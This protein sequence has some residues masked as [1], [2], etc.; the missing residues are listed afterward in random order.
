[1]YNRS[2]KVD[3]RQTDILS[4]LTIRDVKG[5]SLYATIAVSYLI[6]ALVIILVYIY[7]RKMVQLRKD[8]FR[9]PEYQNSFYARTL[10]ITH[11]P[12][13]LQSDKGINSILDT[14]KMPYPATAVHISRQVGVLPE[15][16]KYHNQTVRELEAILVK[17]LKSGKVGSKR[18]T[19]RVGGCCGIGGARKDAIE[20]YTYGV[21]LSMGSC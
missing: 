6:T 5:S 2:D 13:K 18:P 9:S 8:W 3:S 15:L 14:V 20:F 19:I 1:M 12:K 17:Y 4:I 21:F 11:V 7:W 16:I 10:S